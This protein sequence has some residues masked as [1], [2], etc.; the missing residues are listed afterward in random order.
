MELLPLVLNKK[1]PVCKPFSSSSIHHHHRTKNKS[2]FGWSGQ[3]SET[4]LLRC[5]LSRLTSISSTDYRRIY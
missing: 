3:I 1:G 4:P 2:A 5:F